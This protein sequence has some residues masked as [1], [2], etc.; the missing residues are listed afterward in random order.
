MRYRLACVVLC[1]STGALPVIAS[2]LPP[3]VRQEVIALLQRLEVSGCQFNRNGTWYAAPEAKTHLMRKLDYLE[4]NAAILTAE[5][6]IE[7]A[8][9]RSSTSGAAYQVRCGKANEQPSAVW[10]LHE[11]A[12]QRASAKP[13]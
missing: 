10:L 6:F 7:R 3:A 11:L 1:M 4:K 2:P 5:V 8:A 12:L 9:T 13:Q